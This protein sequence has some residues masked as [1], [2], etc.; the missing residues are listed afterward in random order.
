VL[1]DKSVARGQS[2]AQRVD[3]ELIVDDW[4][5]QRGDATSSQGHKLARGLAKKRRERVVVATRREQWGLVCLNHAYKSRAEASTKT[6][7]P[8]S[9]AQIASTRPSPAT[10]SHTA[11]LLHTSTGV[12][13]GSLSLPELNHR[14]D[15]HVQTG[16]FL[17]G[18]EMSGWHALTSLTDPASR[19]TPRLAEM[20]SVKGEQ[21]PHLRLLHRHARCGKART[22]ER[23]SC[24]PTRSLWRT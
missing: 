9:R 22:G 7:T 10:A 17:S 24:T 4:P 21:Q 16:R 8:H 1:C 19:S 14:A 23:A 5:A 3:L 2:T 12:L 18:T 13:H 6:S 15:W 11:F 20:Q